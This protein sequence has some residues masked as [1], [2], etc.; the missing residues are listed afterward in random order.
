MHINCN[1]VWWLPKSWK[2]QGEK[3]KKYFSL[4]EKKLKKK[5]ADKNLIP[6]QN[7]LLLTPPSIPQMPVTQ[8]CEVSHFFV[9][10][11][12]SKFMPH[13]D[14]AKILYLVRT[15]NQSFYLLDNPILQSKFWLLTPSTRFL[16]LSFYTF[17]CC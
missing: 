16:F 4:P 6:H 15:Q 13:K 11:S 12:H 3:K 17:C 1:E 8:T 7:Q 14:E 2:A 9:C 10:V 5:I